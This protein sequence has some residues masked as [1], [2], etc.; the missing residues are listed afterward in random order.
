MEEF[1]GQFESFNKLDGDNSISKLPISHAQMAAFKAQSD[2]STNSETSEEFRQKSI[3]G[4]END[5]KY[6]ME[7]PNFQVGNFKKKDQIDSATNGLFGQSN[8]SG[9]LAMEMNNPNSLSTR[10]PTNT[11]RV[12]NNS[13]GIS[14]T[15]SSTYS[16]E[17]KRYEF[18]SKYDEYKAK[19]QSQTQSV[20]QIPQQSSLLFDRKAPLQGLGDTTVSI[21]NEN[22]VPFNPYSKMQ[23][24]GTGEGLISSMQSQPYELT[25]KYRFNNDSTKNT[26]QNISSLSGYQGMNNHMSN[27]QFF[28]IGDEQDKSYFKI[29]TNLTPTRMNKN[30][31]GLFS[32]GQGFNFANNNNIG[33]FSNSFT[34]NNNPMSLNSHNTSGIQDNINTYGRKLSVDQFKRNSDFEGSLNNRE[35]SN[36]SKLQFNNIKKVNYPSNLPTNG[37]KSLG[38]SRIRSSGMQQLPQMNAGGLQNGQPPLRPP[39]Y[40]GSAHKSNS[41]EQQIGETSQQILNNQKMQNVAKKHNLNIPTDILTYDQ[42][43][44]PQYTMF[45]LAEEEKNLTNYRERVEKEKQKI[46]ADFEHMKHEMNNLLDDLKIELTT[47]VDEHFKQFIERY[48]TFKSEVI[49]FKSIKAELPSIQAPPPS[50]IDQKNASNV[51]LIKELEELRYRNQMSKL[52]Q[53]IGELQKANINRILQASQMLLGQMSCSSSLYNSEGCQKQL[54]ELKNM[55]AMNLSQR[56]DLLSNYVRQVYSQPPNMQALDMNNINASTFIPNLMQQQNSPTQQQYQFS[57]PH[58]LGNPPTMFN[59]SMSNFNSI[60]HPALQ[61]HAYLADS[62]SRAN[63]DQ[64]FQFPQNQ[65]QMI[66]MN[67]LNHFRAMKEDIPE[68]QVGKINQEIPNFGSQMNSQNEEQYSQ[69]FPLKQMQD[70]FNQQQ[71]Q[72]QQH[73]QIQQMPQFSQPFT[74]QNQDEN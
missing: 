9:K 26:S 12:L 73:Q 70:V 55:F 54:K 29:A 19:N 36:D 24:P 63:V 8:F 71:I 61:S 35:L 21:N 30:N 22:N 68:N 32:Q 10:V 14:D 41:Y 31:G 67:L 42:D 28:D 65:N 66:N 11:N 45:L 43:Y 38:E 57:A 53:Y 74:I 64:Q 4:G 48:K 56:F 23:R 5:Q 59:G 52:Y 33:N 2:L 6:Q 39:K 58:P 18:K 17:G 60:Q 69:P 62:P 47:G 51:Q 37:F 20:S 34:N 3:F 1:K 15:P 27:Q 46:E 49:E 13:N 7:S 50:Q 44:F 40:P 72:Q 25:S 16:N